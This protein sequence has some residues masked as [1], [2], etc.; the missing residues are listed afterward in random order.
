MA[1]SNRRQ[2]NLRCYKMEVKEKIEAREKVLSSLKSE[3]K[4]LIEG[5]ED[6]KEDRDT[7]DSKFYQKMVE[8]L[9]G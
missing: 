5:R 7:K 1:G 6:S 4:Q 3:E 8:F 9:E 2:N